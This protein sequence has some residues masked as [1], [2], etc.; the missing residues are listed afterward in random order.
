MTRDE[1][2]ALIKQHVKNKNLI[3]HMLAVE[4][5]M[6]ALAPHFDGDPELWR[7]AGLLHDIDY[8]QTFDK[9]EIHSKLGAQM[10]ADLNLPAE[11]VN[12]VRA[13]NEIHG[14]ERT[15]PMEK[16]LYCSDP[17]TGL[18]VAGALIHPSKKLSAIDKDFILNRFN[19][20]SFAR[21]ANRETIAACKELGLSLEDFV[22][23]ALEAMQQSA[24]ELGL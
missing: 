11:L 23:I 7:L 9:P 5:V 1:A 16:A 12:A 2:L 6:G 17:V 4:V 24:S 13:H 22:T 19:E 18:I 15:T 3:K 10:L 21:G 20:K 8:D 14:I